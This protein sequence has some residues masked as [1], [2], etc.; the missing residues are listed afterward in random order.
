[1]QDENAGPL[2]K[3]QRKSSIKGTKISRFSP[4]FCYFNLVLF[5]CYLMLQFLR[6]R[7]IWR[8]MTFWGNTP[9]A[10][11]HTAHT[12]NAQFP[13]PTVA[14]QPTLCTPT[15][16]GEVIALL[17]GPSP[18]NPQTPR[19]AAISTQGCLRHIDWHDWKIHPSEALLRCSKM[20][21]AASMSCPEMSWALPPEPDPPLQGLKAVAVVRQ[22]QRG[23]G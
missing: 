11:T 21:T 3:R 20:E 16:G 19:S 1:M 6:H 7:D 17:T 18:R 4:F 2:F 15:W 23:R 10:C 13:L 9:C 5:I 12:L 22:E 14:D 8:V